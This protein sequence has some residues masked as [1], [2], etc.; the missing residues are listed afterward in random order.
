MTIAPES[1]LLLVIDVGIQTLAMAQC[2]GQQVAQ[3]LAPDC[4]TLCL[5]NSHKDSLMAFLTYFGQ[6]LNAWCELTRVCGS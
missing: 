4:V 5:T 2:V 1:K 6:I 3:V